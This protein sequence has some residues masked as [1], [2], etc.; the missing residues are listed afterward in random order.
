[1]FSW[2]KV[3]PKFLPRLRWSE[4]RPPKLQV[5]YE[6]S[7]GGC[8]IMAAGKIIVSSVIWSNNNNTRGYFFRRG[9]SLSVHRVD[10]PAREG[11]AVLQGRQWQHAGL[12]QAGLQGRRERWQ[13][14]AQQ[15]GPRTVVGDRA[16]DRRDAGGGE[17]QFLH[18]LWGGGEGKADKSCKDIDCVCQ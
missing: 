5:R 14:R 8:P 4:K 6:D 17:V 16:D 7:L 3:L 12:Q 1:M 15:E 13:R 2:M 9:C 18:T 10:Q 11:R